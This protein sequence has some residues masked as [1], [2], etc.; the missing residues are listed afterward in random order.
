MSENIMGGIDVDKI[1]EGKTNDEILHN[2][3]E[4]FNIATIRLLNLAMDNDTSGTDHIERARKLILWARNYPDLM[5]QK[6]YKNMIDPKNK[7][8]IIERDI[9]YF[10]KK[11]YS[12]FIKKDLYKNTID[13]ILNYIKTYFNI[14][15]E[16]ETS[17][18]WDLVGIMAICS[19]S[20]EK[21]E[22]QKRKR[23]NYSI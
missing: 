11:N 10:S 13:F 15:S 6:C 7:K 21:Y 14:L 17:H 4:P 12:K 9:N 23:L 2:I 22:L 3:V 1:G 8:A 18:I 20:Y 5:I 16:K 19:E